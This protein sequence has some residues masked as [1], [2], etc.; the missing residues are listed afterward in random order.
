MHA[1]L[2]QRLPSGVVHVFAVEL[3]DLFTHQSVALQSVIQRGNGV[4]QLLHTQLSGGVTRVV[5]GAGRRARDGA[6]CG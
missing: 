1:A 3:D 6:A 2:S 4:E 5:S